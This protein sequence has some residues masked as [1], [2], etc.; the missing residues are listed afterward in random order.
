MGYILGYNMSAHV[1][2]KLLVY[3]KCACFPISALERQQERK[4]PAPPLEYTIGGVKIQ[5]PRKAYPS[6]LAMMN[7][8][9]VIL[10]QPVKKVHQTHL[11]FPSPMKNPVNR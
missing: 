2:G 8:V 11:W 10:N 4:M 5:F 9:S 3:K 1:R 6:Q 7:S